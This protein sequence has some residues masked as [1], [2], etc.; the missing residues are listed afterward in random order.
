M[1]GENGGNASSVLKY[2]FLTQ[3]G[4]FPS[5]ESCENVLSMG[6]QN[7]QIQEAYM[8]GPHRSINLDP[9]SYCEFYFNYKLNPYKKE[10]APK[11]AP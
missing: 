9:L 10:C 3:V 11:R 5:V 1:C 8:H 2:T 4:H 6:K 7:T